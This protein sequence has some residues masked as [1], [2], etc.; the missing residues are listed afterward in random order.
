MS[1]Q[2]KISNFFYWGYKVKNYANSR[3]GFGL[4]IVKTLVIGVVESIQGYSK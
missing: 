2:G 1:Q 3:L 4:S